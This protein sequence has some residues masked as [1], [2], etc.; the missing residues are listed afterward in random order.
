MSLNDTGQEIIGLELARTHTIT[1]E[2]GVHRPSV[3]GVPEAFH[4]NRLVEG[5]FLAEGVDHQ[6]VLTTLGLAG[7]V[8]E[9]VGCHGSSSVGGFCAVRYCKATPAGPGGCPVDREVHDVLLVG[10]GISLRTPVVE[11]FTVLVATPVT[12]GIEG[13]T[14]EA[15]NCVSGHDG[16][17]RQDR[18]VVFTRTR[19]HCQG[20]ATYDGCKPEEFVLF[21]NFFVLS[22]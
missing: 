6:E 7:N 9:L 16:L 18:I 3:I 13:C 20:E 14:F 15:D 5:D 4:S 17:R 21:H 10:A 8:V 1:V 12:V 11:L 19:T 22:E 2:D